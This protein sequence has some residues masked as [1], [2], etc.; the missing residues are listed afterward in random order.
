LVCSRKR[1][2]ERVKERTAVAE[3]KGIYGREKKRDGNAPG[4]AQKQVKSEGK[5]TGAKDRIRTQIEN[6]KKRSV[7]KEKKKG[8]EYRR[9]DKGPWSLSRSRKRRNPREKL[10]NCEKRPKG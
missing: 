6:A 3:T 9:I 10:S 8:A 1:S 2:R 4:A 5:S 7:K